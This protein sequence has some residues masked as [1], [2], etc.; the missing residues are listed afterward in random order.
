MSQGMLSFFVLGVLRKVY[1]RF[2]IP[3]KY[4]ND[5]HRHSTVTTKSI[6]I[7]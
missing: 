7:Y 2:K 6:K 5:L 1:L 3:S 4:L